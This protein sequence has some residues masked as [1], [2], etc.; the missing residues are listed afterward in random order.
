MTL[1][2]E[3][4]RP[5]PV[6]VRGLSVHYPTRRTTALDSIDFRILPGERVLLAG[7]S[8]SGKSTLALAIAGLIPTSVP[9][10][11]RGAVLL[12]GATTWDLPA[13]A[14]AELVGVVF[15]DPTSQFTMPRV[16]DEVAFGLENLGRPAGAMRAEVDAA[17]EAV[18]LLDRRDW[19]IDRLSGGQQQRVALAATIA[20]DPG[21]LVLDEPA[22]HLDP[23]SADELY[24]WI[25][26][27]CERQERTVVAVEHSLDHVVA[28]FVSRC[29]VLDRQGRV[30]LD[31]P[32]A[33]VFGSELG[34]RRCAE[35]GV[36]LPAAVRL[37]LL[38]GPDGPLPLTVADAASWIVAGH[39][40]AERL[41]AAAR[42]AAPPPRSAGQV[43][44]EASGVTVRYRSPG[45]ER[46][47]VRDAN[48]AV[49]AG[50]LVALVGPNGSGKSTLLRAMSGLVPQA[51]GSVRIDGV[52][53]GPDTLG[54][55]RVGHVF[56][57][58]EAGFL[59]DTVFGEVA[60]G[61]RAA[62]WPEDRITER[63]AHVLGRFGLEGLAAANPFTLSEGQKRR[64]S[65]AAA[66]IQ[67]PNLLVLDE[68][69]FGQDAHAAAML[70][71][72]IAAICRDGTAVV[73][74]THDV[75]LVADVADRVVAM[76][77]GAILGE[78][79]PADFFADDA[80]LA[81]TAQVRPPLDRILAAV[82][83]LGA[84]VPSRLRWADLE[85]RLSEKPGSARSRSLTLPG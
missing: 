6:T 65:I 66:V 25:H 12:D 10:E 24:G 67:R 75:G 79:P 82:Q 21:I 52:E 19:L 64:L 35:L 85:P 34:A 39:G 14:A 51:T 48:L 27:L 26:A 46:V 17:L 41:R 80:L 70:V 59:A 49:R 56:Q 13:G 36:W 45:H 44:L 28:G 38:L 37:A 72:E 16:E 69:T 43:I 9:A 54:P 68:P 40:R 11:V 61:P 76:A 74:A 33:D 78:M 29:L 30:A 2:P 73:I 3:G 5:V 47:A 7:P 57:N 84:E 50:E 83:A 1:V 15:Q 31:G 60:H 63:V 77:D 23:H 42:D 22:A 8:G 62:G 18:N 58:P 20:M 71:E 4:G 81:A 55:E 32:I 53:M